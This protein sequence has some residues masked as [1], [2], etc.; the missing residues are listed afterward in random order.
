VAWTLPCPGERLSL[1]LS[2]LLCPAWKAGLVD[3]SRDY[4]RGRCMTNHLL[5]SAEVHKT[6]SARLSTP[7]AK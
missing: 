4:A 2:Q 1:V 5:R 3:R 7:A 6:G